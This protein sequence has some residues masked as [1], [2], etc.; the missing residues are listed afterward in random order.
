[1]A[2]KYGTNGNDRVLGSAG[3]EWLVGYGGNDAIWG[4]AGADTFVFGRGHGNDWVMDLDA[5]EGDRVVISG[6]SG[7][8]IVHIQHAHGVETRFGGLGGTGPDSVFFLGADVADVV[9]AL[10][11]VGDNWFA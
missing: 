1:M 3:A 10:V 8:E 6:C 11:V 4:R 7:R 5:D 9:K 2:A